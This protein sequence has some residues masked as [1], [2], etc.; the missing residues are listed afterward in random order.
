MEA[1]RAH[2]SARVRERALWRDAAGWLPLELSGG[3]ET[4]H[5]IWICPLR[6]AAHRDILLEVE[7]LPVSGLLLSDVLNVLNNCEDPI[8]IK[9]VKS[10]NYYGTPK[11]PNQPLSRTLITHDALRDRFTGSQKS[12]DR[13][14]HAGVVQTELQED[15]DSRAD[16]NNTFTGDSSRPDT[17]GVV[18]E[19]AP[20]YVLN[21]MAASPTSKHPG[22]PPDQDPLGPLPDNWETAYTENGEI[23]FIDHNTKT[24]SWMDPRCQDKP[25][26]PLEDCEDDEG[27]HTEELD[28][29]L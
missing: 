3:A 6:S 7:G 19:N 25:P 5:F 17:H 22:L 18:R 8:R 27:V 10:G 12:C 14:Q 4:G 29:D 9:T 21:N 15:A 13:M 1:S 11:P 16:M 28:T 24:T 26:K 23:Y 2:W 20:T